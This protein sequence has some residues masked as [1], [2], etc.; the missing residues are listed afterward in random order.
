MLN[1][2]VEK[3][4]RSRSF[5]CSVELPPDNFLRLFQIHEEECTGFPGKPRTHFIVA[6]LCSC[7]MLFFH[8]LLAWTVSPS[9]FFPYCLWKV[10]KEWRARGF[11]DWF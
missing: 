4:I 6:Q 10:D 2:Q 7:T 1:D 11:G 8:D 5:L 9:Y 3:W